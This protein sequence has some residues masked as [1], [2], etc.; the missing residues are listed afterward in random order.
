MK[1]QQKIRFLYFKK[2]KTVVSGIKDSL[3]QGLCLSVKKKYVSRELSV[4]DERS[5]R[6]IG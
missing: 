1:I 5:G 6:G 3:L 4:I 2:N